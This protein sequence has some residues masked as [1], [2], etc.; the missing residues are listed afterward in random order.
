MFQSTFLC[1]CV[2]H[3]LSRGASLVSW[4]HKGDTDA[5]F[6]RSILPAL[7]GDPVGFQLG[8]SPTSM[9]IFP[10]PV[11]QIPRVISSPTI[12]GY[13]KQHVNCFWRSGV[14][15]VDFSGHFYKKALT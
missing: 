11:Q 10:S 8:T 9:L 3:L 4:S 5:L 2:T 6:Q 12:V 15:V 14:V 7:R 1:V 13:K